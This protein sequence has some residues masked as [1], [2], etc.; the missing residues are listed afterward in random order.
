MTL[1]AGE[2][3]KSHKMLMH[4]YEKLS[5]S[6][7][8]RSGGIVALGGGVI[9]DLAGYAAATYIRGINFVQIP[10]TLLA[11]VD[12]SVGGKT[13]IDL[14]FAKNIV[15]AFH[16]PQLVL[17]DTSTLKTLSERQYNAGMAE[18]I[19]Y[20]AIA[21]ENLNIN[22]EIAD[23][24]Y[25]CCELKASYVA[26]DP[27]DTGVR[28]ELNFGHTLGHA[29]ETVS[30]FEVLHGEGVAIGMAVFSKLG[31]NMGVTEQGTHDKI[32]ALLQNAHLP[33]KPDNYDKSALFGAMSK[34]KKSFG[35]EITVVLPEKFGRATLRKIKFG[36]M[37][38]LLGDVL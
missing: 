33:F 37:T 38:R 13:G 17:A 26:K 18:V 36:E 14:P 31:E 23:V 27:F 2:A 7:I 4:V 5:S 20:A 1:P 29:I 9:G 12:S 3:T 8:N 6:G 24:V 11:Q 10:T 30:D 22:G 32:V 19:K 35:R 34:D 25:R 28:M 15:G 16:Q 21:D